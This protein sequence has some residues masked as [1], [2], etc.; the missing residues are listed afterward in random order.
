MPKTTKKKKGATQ[1]AAK[2][3]KSAKMN[4]ASSHK[5]PPALK[6]DRATRAA[7]K[8][9]RAKLYD[10]WARGIN[11]TAVHDK[12]GYAITTIK[13]DFQKFAHD[14][15]DSADVE[16]KRSRAQ[17]WLS[18]AVAQADD[19]YTDANKH[20]ARGR[21]SAITA[22]LKAVELYAKING[23]LV[24]KIEHG[25]SIEVRDPR[26]EGIPDETLRAAIF[27][28]GSKRRGGRKTRGG[29]ATPADG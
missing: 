19:T 14:A 15:A 13:K 1:K 18:T 28:F 25:G 22:K 29:R 3:K 17:A 9:R 10:F 16:D 12:T 21:S 2:P 27:A 7:A 23:L 4:G 5:K 24:E 6:A 11:P 8:K 20:D 26:L